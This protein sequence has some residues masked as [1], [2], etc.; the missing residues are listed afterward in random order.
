[1][2]PTG[3]QIPDFRE[4]GYLPEGLFLASAAEI[5]FRFGTANRQRRRLVLRLRRW[6]ELARAISARRLFIDGSFVTTKLEPN[7]IDAVVLLP[8]DFESQIAAE[9][10]GA[11][12][13]E[14]MLLSR[15]PE[16]IVAAEDTA[17]WLE[18]IEFFGRTRESDGR[19]KGLVEIEL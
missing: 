9:F 14:Q 3:N 7:D 12:E 16:E 8:D 2:L 10:E 11:I 5:T 6:I 18:W 4:D 15:R 13:F 19:R 1:M 17:D